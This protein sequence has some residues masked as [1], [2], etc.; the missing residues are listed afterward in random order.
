MSTRANKAWFPMDLCPISFI[1][2]QIINPARDSISCGCSGALIAQPICSR[3]LA[4]Q[5]VYANC[6]SSLHQAVYIYIY[7]LPF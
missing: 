1:S 2:Q 3:F 5:D 4:G 7:I 6:L